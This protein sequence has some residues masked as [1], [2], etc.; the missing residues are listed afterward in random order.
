MFY[1][2]NYKFSGADEEIK[3]RE[4]ETN[5]WDIPLLIGCVKNKQINK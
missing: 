2:Q 4:P 5:L 1:H 3:L